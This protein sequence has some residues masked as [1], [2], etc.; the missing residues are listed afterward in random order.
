M[1]KRLSVEIEVKVPAPE[2]WTV[3]GSLLLAKIAVEELS[4]QFSKLEVLKGDGSAGTIIQVFCTSGTA[5][6]PWYKEV[7]KVVDEER[8]VKEAE[9][10]EGGALD[11]GFSYF[12][13]VLEVKEKEGK[14]EESIVR[15]TIVYELKDEAAGT[16]VSTDGL[17]NILN[18]A[19]DYLIKNHHCN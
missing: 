10:V 9:V 7:F 1:V 19:A 3:Y 4:D 6:R 5:E 15:G 17:L 11:Q 12:G 8:L 16:A 18:L 13:T 14:K 2:A